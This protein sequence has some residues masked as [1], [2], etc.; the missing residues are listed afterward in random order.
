MSYSLLTL[1]LFHKLFDDKLAA[2]FYV[3]SHER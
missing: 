3:C 2:P 1:G